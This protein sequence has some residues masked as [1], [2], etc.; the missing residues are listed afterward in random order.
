MHIKDSVG[1]GAT[2]YVAVSGSLKEMRIVDPGF[3]Y[4][5]VPTIKIT[6][7]NGSGARVSVNMENIDHSSDFYSYSPLVGLGTTGTLA[8]TIGFN[9]FHKFKNAEEVVY[10]TNNQDVVGGLTTSATYY[11]SL[12]GTGGTTLRLH[13]DEAGAL[14]GI[15][16]IVLTSRGQGVQSLKSFKTK[17]IVESINIISTGSGYQNKKRTAVPAGISTALNLSLIH[18]SEPTRPY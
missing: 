15:N 17:S 10:I 12:V 7:G 3:D 16:T 9:T 13:K 6:G 11:A 1:T 18:I 8:S 14:A 5:E 4:E 2:G